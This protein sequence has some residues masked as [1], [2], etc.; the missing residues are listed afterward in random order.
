MRSSRSSLV[1]VFSLGLA[2]LGLVQAGSSHAGVEVIDPHA[3]Y[4]EGPLWDRGR[5]LFVEYAGPGIKV[6]DGK[7]TKVWWRREHCG[8]DAL[9]HFRDDHLLVACYDGNYLVELD[10]KGRTLRTFDKDS[11][12]KPFVG[13]NDFS[14]DGHGGVY[15]SASGV[16]D[17]KAPITGAVLHLSGDGRDIRVVADTI[18][19]SN[20]LTLSKDGTHL[21]V[22]EMLAGRVLSFPI[23][24]ND[25]LGPRTV[26]A[27][28]QDLAPPT[29]NEDAYNG[30]DGIKLGPDGNYYIAQ[31]GSGRVLVVTEEKKLVRAIEV[32][33]RYVTNVG[34]GQKGSPDVF[35][36]GAFDPWKA[37]FPGAVYRWTP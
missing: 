30:P 7:G 37:P 11:A 6:W 21:L 13:P 35:I 12:G 15:F 20:G 24:A 9:I 23:E 10:A 34:F 19:Y 33:T 8:A 29:P 5:L 22:A 25:T 28:L 2:L 3:L 36:T 32:G 18:H 27:R 14:S 17:I 4:P 31:N 16:F 1:A 26:W